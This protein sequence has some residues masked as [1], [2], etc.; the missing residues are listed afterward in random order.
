MI[1]GY[2]DNFLPFLEEIIMLGT[3]FPFPGFDIDDHSPVLLSKV[4]QDDHIMWFIGIIHINT[5]GPHTENLEHE[6]EKTSHIAHK[7]CK[8]H[9]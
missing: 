9:C 1:L 6:K 5:A 7:D 3:C 4:L 8:E 2:A